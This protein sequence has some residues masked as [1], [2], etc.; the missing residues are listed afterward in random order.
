MLEWMKRRFES[1]RGVSTLEYILLAI[2]IAGVVAAAGKVIS[3]KT[4]EKAQKIGAPHVLVVESHAEV[5]V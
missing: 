1:D 4:K 5:G 3:D 2:V